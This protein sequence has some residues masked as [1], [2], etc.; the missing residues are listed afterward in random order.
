L[1]P[2]ILK[3]GESKKKVKKGEG[4]GKSRGGVDGPGL[5]VSPSEVMDLQQTR[6]KKKK[7]VAKP[8]M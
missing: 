6:K 7:G 2:K 8:R 1:K 3:G 5:V 4:N